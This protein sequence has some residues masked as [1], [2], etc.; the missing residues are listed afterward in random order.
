ML[1][2]QIAR[3]FL[4]RSKLQS[5]LIILGIGVGIGTQVFVGSLIASLQASLIDTT[6][7]SSPHVTLEPIDDGERIAYTDALA[8]RLESDPAIVAI[9]PQQLVSVLARSGDASDPLVVRLVERGARDGIYGLDDRIVDGDADPG[10]GEI[11]I[12]LDYAEEAGLEVGDETSLLVDSGEEVTATVSGIFDLGVAGVNLGTAFASSDLLDLPTDAFD[13]IELQVSD[14]FDSDAVAERLADIEGITTS[15]WQEQNREL[16]T[17][18][19]SQSVS[20]IMIQVF[21]VI[22][23]GLGIA[24]TL[25]I[26]AVQKTRQIGILKAL[27]LSDRRSGTVFLWQAALLGLFGTALG[28]AVGWG[29]IAGFDAAASGSE[30]LFPVDVDPV[31]AAVSA[32]IGMAIALLSALIPYRSTSRLD[33]IAVIQNG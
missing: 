21:V 19:Q 28:L 23:V 9:A 26:A 13:R 29:L 27:G 22:A 24:S 20:S 18:L 2:F 3:R 11:V 5:T 8:S 31:F 15:D 33:P 7:G 12:G 32:A 1:P 25:A 30:A 16:L 6:V 17:G 14:V 4:W 10:A